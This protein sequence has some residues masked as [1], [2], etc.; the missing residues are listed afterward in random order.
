MKK[1]Q[2]TQ[3]KVAVVD[4]ED[5]E[6]L[7]GSRWHAHRDRRTFYATRGIR[8]PDGRPTKEAMHRIVLS[9]KLRR[10]LVK[11]E[12]TDH[13]N[14][15]G[16][17]NQRDNLRLATNAQNMRNC[18]RRSTNPSSQY[19]GVS[20]HRHTR[21]WRAQIRADGKKI[22]LGSYETELAAAQ[23]REAYIAARPELQARS[24]FPDRAM[25]DRR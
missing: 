3:G 1:I 18:R 8:L 16:L 2:L 4:D 24:N 7:S 12:K 5:Y 25:E 20:W 15:D 11:G 9:R 14:G 10:P 6:A 19:L 22:H 13:W 21:K 17:D 23:D